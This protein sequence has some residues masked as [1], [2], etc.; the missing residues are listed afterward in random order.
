MSYCAIENTVEDLTI[1]DEVLRDLIYFQKPIGEYE[2]DSLPAFINMCR[3]LIE[4]YDEGVRD[5]IID[6]NGR[7]Q[8]EQEDEE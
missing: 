6:K 1:C 3:E 7:L 5:G 2:Q 4:L 8:S